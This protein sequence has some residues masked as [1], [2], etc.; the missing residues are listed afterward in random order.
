MTKLPLILAAITITQAALAVEKKT[1]VKSEKTAEFQYTCV[2][3]I[4]LNSEVYEYHNTN[5]LPSVVV[6]F[7]NRGEP[8]TG[9]IEKDV[10]VAMVRNSSNQSIV[11]EDYRQLYFDAGNNAC[12]DW[13]TKAKNRLCVGDVV[14]VAPG[15]Y[16]IDND[17]VETLA[18]AFLDRTGQL[19]QA[20]I[21]KVLKFNDD[22]ISSVDGNKIN[23][24]RVVLSSDDLNLKSFAIRAEAIASIQKADCI[25]IQSKQCVGDTF[26]TFYGED[27]II[28]AVLP[29]LVTSYNEKLGS[30]F[31]SKLEGLH[32][33]YRRLEFGSFQAVQDKKMLQ[34]VSKPRKD[35]LTVQV[36]MFTNEKNAKIEIRKKAMKV[37]E[38]ACRNTSFS[39]GIVDESKT[40]ITSIENCQKETRVMESVG[41]G[42][43]FPV[44]TKPKHYF[45]CE[46][47]MVIGCK[48]KSL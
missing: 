30:V 12:I 44:L 9:N 25:G 5:G 34:S 10:P 20:R 22:I 39:R 41:H 17:K 15:T 18:K 24:N 19:P 45:E 29:G 3:K 8:L 4:C 35:N 21:E 46:V 7:R 27:G 31:V 2:R 11:P 13:D 26:K 37:A 36:G 38:D 6:G 23:S 32:S 16:R 28:E 47:E 40:A 48:D 43:T 14:A 42:I 33:S 1:T